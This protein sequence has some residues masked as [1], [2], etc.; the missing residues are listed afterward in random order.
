MELYSNNNLYQTY[1]IATNNDGRI[2]FGVKLPNDSLI[3]NLN[4]V[5]KINYANQFYS[6]YINI[7]LSETVYD[8]QFL[9]ESG[10]L[11]QR[12]K[13]KLA[14]KALNYFGKPVKVKGVIYNQNHDSI[15][16]FETE[17]NGMGVID[18]NP[19]NTKYYAKHLSIKNTQISTL[20]VVKEMGSVINVVSIHD[21]SISIAIK[22]TDTIHKHL[23]VR[24]ANDI[25]L[26]HSV[27]M[28]NET[29]VINTKTLPIGVYQL[30]LFDNSWNP[31]CQRLVFIQL[32]KQMRVD[33][34]FEKT[35]HKPKD[36]E[37][38]NIK[39][40][41]ENNQAVEGVFSL[42]VVNEQMLQY[43]DQY[44]ENL[45]SKM[46]LQ[47]ELKSDVYAPSYYFTDIHFTKL[48]QL[49]LVM[50]TNGWSRLEWDSLKSQNNEINK[51][52]N[53]FLNE[54]YII[55]G[56]INLEKIKS[57]D[58][59]HVKLQ[60]L[61]NHQKIPLDSQ[62]NFTI[63]G[64][65]SQ[66]EIKLKVKFKHH[67]SKKYKIKPWII[68]EKVRHESNAVKYLDIKDTA[69]KLALL[70][71][72]KSKD[73]KTKSAK[74]KSEDKYKSIVIKKGDNKTKD[75]TDVKT[76]ENQEIHS[77]KEVDIKAKSI[78]GMAGITSKYS[79]DKL[80]TIYSNYY[81]VY[82]ISYYSNNLHVDDLLMLELNYQNQ[83]YNYTPLF[84]QYNANSIQSNK[85]DL[86]KTLT[87]QYNIKTNSKGEAELNYTNCNDNGSYVCQIEGISN[88]GKFISYT[89]KY[90]VIKP[91]IITK[92]IPETLT[93]GDSVSVLINIEN[94]TD[95]MMYV[96]ST[97][98]IDY[99][100]KGTNELTIPANKIG[101]IN[102]PL[103]IYKENGN[104]NSL[105]KININ[106]DL[107]EFNNNINIK[108]KL[109]KNSFSKSN[110]SGKYNYKIFLDSSSVD[111][112]SCKLTLDIQSSQLKKLKNSLIAMVREPHGC[113]EQVSSSNYPNILIY[114]LLQSSNKNSE[115]E[116]IKEKIKIGYNKL[117]AYETKEKGFEW[118][119]YTPPHEGLT[120]YG[121]LQFHEM[122]GIVEMDSNL[123]K[124]T[125]K[126][127]LSR[128]K[129]DGSIEVN[130]GKYGFSGA[131]EPITN[132][133]V[134]WVLSEINN[135]IDL[136]A[137]IQHLEKV[138]AQKYDTY[139]ALLLS[140]IYFNTN[141]ADKGQ[142]LLS[143]C[144]SHAQIKNYNNLEAS[145]SIVYSYGNYLDI[146]LIGMLIYSMLKNNHE[147]K[148][149]DEVYYQLIKRK[150]INGL[151]GSTQSTIWALK[152]MIMYDN[153]LKTKSKTEIYPFNENIHIKLND[154]TI[155]NM[156][157]INDQFV[158][159][160]INHLKFGENNIEI[161]F[162]ARE[163][164]LFSLNLDYLNLY[165]D[166][167]SKIIKLSNNAENKTYNIGDFIPINYEFKNLRDTG[168]G[169]TLIVIPL[170][171][172]LTLIPEQLKLL[173]E[174]KTVDYYE[175][176]NGNLVLYF[177]E[178]GPKEIKN[179]N[180]SFISQ[181]SGKTYIPPAY[182]YLYYNM[183]ESYYCYP[184]KII[185]K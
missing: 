148:S 54:K 143:K 80:T 66:D 113:F 75:K 104:L 157:Q 83:F 169:Q 99:T 35:T 6:K 89:T 4:L 61:N 147:I 49:D 163:N 33:L 12:I 158:E 110:Q 17:H 107:E 135:T 65:N 142:I 165:P 69:T 140:N 81:D 37:K 149:I 100:L 166:E 29:I 122:K 145:H 40:K 167:Q 168:L 1:N 87:Y 139:I 94:N 114:K 67:F 46:L 119:G 144:L 164:K 50:L 133:Y 171:G 184:N 22:S 57:K 70:D 92:Q 39:I 170:S 105:L 43:S 72:N 182:T 160:P 146:E 24:K 63:W 161:N 84:S 86:R 172:S 175:I 115:L 77:I 30:T 19:H 13:T 7:P 137:N 26:N 141:Q 15:C 44:R 96:N 112:N 91:Y 73:L 18:F 93:A 52:K 62:G 10:Y 128:I 123:Y 126:W 38:V 55:R 152:S 25:Y 79:S 76:F 16:S 129:K 41:D 136:S 134:T 47:N 88:T 11:I 31:I 3:V 36:I 82:G 42:S 56:K 131:S 53:L 124:R 155:L 183:N 68:L 48:K 185:V 111:F 154:V 178:I 60:I 125:I 162:E 108:P 51:R 78:V 179:I 2:E 102:F 20:P 9:P 28:Q 74:L 174:K 101:K 14:F 71:E 21:D 153:Y 138:L 27:R 8:L 176:F 59:K 120:A 130:R 106:G 117:A 109:F 116:S 177:A 90:S 97:W 118:Y 95:S 156:N 151:F 173:K 85:N 150:T 5:L 64:I 58:K 34:N 132:A 181:V 45:L 98:H 23:I 103:I 180:I 121:L 32:S 159:L 127:L